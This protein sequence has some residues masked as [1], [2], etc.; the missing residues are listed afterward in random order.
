MRECRIGAGELLLL[1]LID[2]G[3]GRAATAGDGSGGG[4]VPVAAFAPAAAAAAASSAKNSPPLDLWSA[5]GVAS[6]AFS[7]LQKDDDGDAATAEPSCWWG[8]YGSPAVAWPSAR[9]ARGLAAPGAAAL[10]QLLL[11][12]RAGDGGGGYLVALR[13]MPQQAKTTTTLPPTVSLQLLVDSKTRAPLPVDGT[14]EAG[15]GAAA[16][17]P[18]RLAAALAAALDEDEEEQ[19]QQ[20]EDQEERA[21]LARLAAS[22]LAGRRLLPGALVPLPLMGRALWACVAAS[23]AETVLHVVPGTRVE[24]RLGSQRRRRANGKSTTAAPAS[25]SPAN[26]TTTTDL[27]RRARRAAEAAVSGSGRAAAADAAER[28]VL[29]GLAA[30]RAAP[31]GFASLGGAAALA[32][33]LRQC[34]ALPLRRPALFRAFGVRPPRG[35]LLHGPPGSGKSAAA[36]AAAF[37]C[38]AQLLVL[39]GPA[40][41]SEFFGESEAGLR[42]VFA[43]ADALSPCVLFLDEVDSLAPARGGGGGGGGGISGE[44]AHAAAAGVG[45]GSDPSGRVLTQLLT[46]MD[47][48][49]GAGEG[50]AAATAAAA[51]PDASA[52]LPPKPPRPPRVVIIAATNR[53]DALDPAMR[54]PGRLEREILVGPPDAAGRAEILRKRLLPRGGASDDNANDD[55]ALTAAD[56][57]AVAAGA[58]GFVGA[59]LAALANEAAM[60]AL[61]RHVAALER[62]GAAAAGAAAAAAS[63][64]PPTPTPRVTRADLLAARLRVSPSALRE[65]SVEVP[66]ASWRDV[67]G[68]EDVKARLREAVEWPTR[69][70]AALA[71]AGARPPRG[72]LLYGPPGCSK[73]LLARAAAAEARVNFL[74]VRGGELLSAYVGA[75]ERAVAALFRRARASAPALVFFDEVDALA[76]DRGGGGG[77]SGSGSRAVSQLLV[78]MD[79]CQPSLGVVV[80]AATNRPDRVDPALLRPGRLD[81]LLHVRPPSAQERAE[82]LRLKLRRTP[83]EDGTDLGEVA[84]RAER[85]TGADLAAVAREAAVLALERSDSAVSQAHLLEALGRVVPSAPAPG[86]PMEE[87]YRRFERAGG[88]GVV[89]EVEEEEE[90]G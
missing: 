35:V 18:L 69:R 15:G 73:T 10:G 7:T 34:V 50:A 56:I 42:G 80:L 65:V 26:T 78:E 20:Q 23:P 43:A 9:V 4:A 70:A 30:R 29:A 38:G 82:I 17:W 1:S 88:G 51:A 41:M 27:V 22:H 74:S 60:G 45:G 84:R 5:A 81:L 58:H 66:K 28:A 64:A 59:D 62:G 71:A 75:S 90:G 72:V 14:A 79:G 11:P 77:G 25:S 85:C 47:G 68:L 32:R 87:V 67:G 57:E 33:E 44:S 76:G 39:D 86:D 24:L 40:V 21:L 52:P 37:D 36:R 46:L 19:Q 53:P 83:L 55:D 16:T 54:R 12:P 6:E 31:G 63:C 3:N 61:R 8:R 13:R 48:A 49:E 2:D 89:V